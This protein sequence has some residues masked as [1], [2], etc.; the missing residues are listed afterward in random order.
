MDVDFTTTLDDVTP[1]TV[2]TKNPPRAVDV[3]LSTDVM[4]TFSESVVQ[5]STISFVLRDPNNN[6]VPSSLN[7]DAQSLTAT[8]TLDATPDERSTHH[9][10]NSANCTYRNT[11]QKYLRSLRLLPISVDTHV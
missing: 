3:S 10:S 8:L 4:A 9:A 7:Y 6:L 11:M 5:P 1:P 2:V